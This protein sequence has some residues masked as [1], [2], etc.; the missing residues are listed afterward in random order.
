MTV[1]D[2]VLEE[3]QSW[4]FLCP[5]YVMEMKAPWHP[6]VYRMDSSVEGAGLVATQASLEEIED[7]ARDSGTLGWSAVH[8]DLE[9]DAD[10]DTGDIAREPHQKAFRVLHLFACPEREGFLT[11]WL[12]VKAGSPGWEVTVDYIDRWRKPRHDISITPSFM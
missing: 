12:K 10:D 4:L 11:G 9:E 6:T 5:L 8:E 1:P 2:D 7:E 3:F